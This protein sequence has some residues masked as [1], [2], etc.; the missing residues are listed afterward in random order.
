MGCA[1]L[2]TCCKAALCVHKPLQHTTHKV[3]AMRLTKT[4]RKQPKSMQHSA[5][6]EVSSTVRQQICKRKVHCCVHNGPALVSILNCTNP[7]IYSRPSIY[8]TSILI[9]SS[10]LP[11]RPS[12]GFLSSRCPPKIYNLY[13]KHV[14]C[15]Q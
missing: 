12:S 8:L 2:C 14:S 10:H 4:Y 6:E 5:S 3:Y 11:L 1:E 13:F 15:S 7:T 9:L